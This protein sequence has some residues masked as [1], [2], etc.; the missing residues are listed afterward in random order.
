MVNVSSIYSWTTWHATVQRHVPLHPWR[1]PKN[2]DCHTQDAHWRW[3][4]CQKVISG[5][6]TKSRVF[7]DRP[8]AQPTPPPWFPDFMGDWEFRCH[9]FNQVQFQLTPWRVSYFWRSA[10]LSF[11]KERKVYNHWQ[12]KRRYVNGASLLRAK[13]PVRSSSILALTLT[14]APL[15]YETGTWP[16]SIRSG[17]VYT[18][19]TVAIE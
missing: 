7:I 1:F 11:Y 9:N 17:R 3:S 13:R 8:R 16:L 10:R 18:K 5:S 4:C 12:W 2:A 6:P 19:A 14:S 15:S